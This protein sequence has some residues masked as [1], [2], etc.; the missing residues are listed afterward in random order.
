MSKDVACFYD[1]EMLLHHPTGWDPE[2]PDWTEAVKALLAAQYPE[3]NPEAFGHPERPDRISVI[4]ERLLENG[5]PGL[6]WPEFEA[7][8]SAALRRVHADSYVDYIESFDGRSGWLS[9]DTTAVSPGSVRAAKLAAGAGVAAVDSVM[10]GS[11][12]RAFCLVRPPGH[13]ALPDRAMGFCLFNNVGVA[14][15]HALA[16]HQC[17]RVLIYDWDLHH[18][19]GTQEM[20]YRRGDVLYVDTHCAPPFYPG[21][22]LMEE[23]GEGDGTGLTVNVPLPLQSGNTTHLAAFDR[24][25]AP[26]AELFRPDL[27]LVSAGFDLHRLDQIMAV[28]E[29]GFGA[30]CARVARLADQHC[31]GRVVLMLEGGYH[32]EALAGG[33]EACVR[34]LAGEALED[35]END[36]TDPGLAAVDAAAVF[37]GL[38]PKTPGAG[39]GG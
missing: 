9:V 31:N 11:A 35:T 4:R 6:L 14:A 7:A 33:A 29:A 2:H 23:T 24:I 10:T 39:S 27:I 22:G 8:E 32:A 28:D 19:N 34:A 30:L 12:K 3:G 37:H 5:P 20:F 21:S 25:V 1:E 16:A 13:H 18:G 38:A 15:A 26:A 17:R 36:D